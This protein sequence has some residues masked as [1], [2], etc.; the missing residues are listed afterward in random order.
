MNDPRL[1]NLL[2]WGVENSEATRN[3]PDGTNQPKSELTPEMLAALMGGPSDADLMRE[4]MRAITSEETDLENKLTAF[5][6]FEQLVEQI[7]N[8]NNIEALGLWQPL[9]EQLKSEEAELRRM[10]AWCVGTAVQNNVKAQEKLLEHDGIPTITKMAVGDSNQGARKK[11]INALSSVTR[12]F[13]PG[14]DAAVEHLPDAYHGGRKLDAA[15]MDDVDSIINK[16]REENAT[17]A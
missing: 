14:L 6:N 11:A 17:K 16:L 5:D 15:S 10:A 12:N 13:Q 7:D 8:A 9:L 1:N 2:R 3:N 4:A